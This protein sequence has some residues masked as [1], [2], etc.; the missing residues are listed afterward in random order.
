[1]TRQEITRIIGEQ[2]HTANIEEDEYSYAKE[3]GNLAKLEQAVGK[4]V[5]HYKLD[6]RFEHNSDTGNY[7][8]L[9]ETKQIFV[10]EDAEQL[11]AYLEE[12]R[13]LHKGRKVICILANTAN[14]D[15]RVWKSEINDAHLLKEETVLE[16]M[17]HYERLFAA[18]TW[19]Q[20]QERREAERQAKAQEQ[21]NS[22]KGEDLVWTMPYKQYKEHYSDCETVVGSYDNHEKE[23]MHSRRY[24][25]PTITV[26]IREG[27]LKNSGVRGEHYSGYRMENERGEWI[28]Y[29]AVKEENALKRVSKDFP[30]HD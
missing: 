21:I 27:R 26:I 29:R 25:P 22:L 2:Y 4:K 16:S 11:A 3:A 20:I 19:E 14:N 23:N 13:A 6:R 24:Y 30:G 8:V 28:T 5:K 17:E 1:M 15:I 18:E 12:E 9:V 10:D 7:V